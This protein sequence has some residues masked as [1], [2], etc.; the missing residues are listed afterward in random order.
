MSASVVKA[1]SK[2][3][4]KATGDG[5]YLLLE[6]VVSAADACPPLKSVAGGALHIATLVR[7]RF[8]FGGCPIWF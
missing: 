4:L 8:G 6:A 7:V 3:L 1:N 2:N 5:A